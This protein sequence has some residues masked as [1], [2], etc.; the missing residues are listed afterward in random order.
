LYVRE[1][2]GTYDADF[3]WTNLALNMIAFVRPYWRRVV[4][5]LPWICG[6]LLAAWCYVIMIVAARV[7]VLGRFDDGIE[8]TTVTYLLHGQLAFTDF[9]EPY[10]I[11]LGIPG[12]LPHLLGIDS[13]FA[14]RLVYGVFPALVTLLVTPLVW[15]R[16]GAPMGVLVGLITITST[17]PRYSMGFAALFGFALIVDSAVRRTSTGTL[18]EAVERRPR[19]FLAAS[20]VCSLAGWARTEYAIFA[21]LWAVVLMLVLPRGRRRWVLS[22]A[23]ALFAA[24]PTLIVLV[25]GGL[26]HLW[27]FISYTLSS[28]ESGF[29]AQRGQPIE[30]HLLVDRL[31]ELLHLQFGTSTANTIVG[32][33]GLGLAV[34]LAGVLMLLV[35]GWR[36]RLLNRDSSYLTPFMIFACAVV[37][38]G[39]AARFSTSY[40]SIGNPV[41]W[42]AG[43]LLLGRLPSWALV[44]VFAFFAYP[45]A[46]GISPGAVY[47]TWQSRPPV[48]N[49]VV[50]PG[51][52]WIPIAE[53][54]GPAS[55][56]AL[57]AEWRALGL[58]GRPA[59]NVELRNDVAW[60]NDAIV[61]FLLN[62]P[63][64]AWPLTY[65]PG[66]VNTT[67]VER[68]T[69]AELC[70]NRAPVVQNNGDYPYTSGVKV[71]VGSRLLD[72]F[73]AVDYEVRAVAGFYRILMPSTPRCEL[74]EQ[75]NDQTLEALGLKWLEKGELA[76]AGALAIARLER[77]RSRHEQGSVS[78]AALAALGGYTLTSDELPA[79]DLGEAL[80]A[81]APGASP[82]KG[83]AA[84]AANP[85]PSDIERLA[86]QTAWI[87]HRS[88]GEA[89]TEQAAADVY[90][91]ALR[92]ANWPQAIANL[93]AIE[94]PSPGL[95]VTLAR[96][97][98]QGT[99]EFD[100]WRRGYFV[101]SGDIKD[102]IAAGLE[103]TGDYDRRR[104]PVEAGQAEL[105]LAT[106][107]GVT[108]GCA[109]TLRR[110][111]GMHSG[112]RVVVPP[113]GPGCTQ[114]EL[115]HFAG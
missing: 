85:W 93:S 37:L 74:P 48:N 54:G 108:P 29:H 49:R 44:V 103:L 100:R 4:P 2:P 7:D 21:A 115:A 53:D 18:Q 68:E 16:C 8:Y 46:P 64:A 72:E 56:A 6:T 23:T 106:Y 88:P 26:R 57:I 5:W 63:A 40:G 83:L 78:D 113:T 90:S 35:P 101:E 86:A 38:Y 58:D 102:S 20:I 98:A 3:C 89:G 34:V 62:A 45:F 104:D 73:L 55:M 47:D 36:Q 84:A 111:A 13:V 109:L 77:A 42:V 30:W 65:D 80:R 43:A 27:W 70:R 81:L 31:T 33:Y 94:P 97:G 39:Q 41:F 69:V 17:V 67:K 12:V 14:L 9:Y 51:F 79:G 28:S 32:S 52:N 91:L 92:R 112:V 105:E 61:G 19:L 99:P 15:R 11:G 1:A 114:P 24:L 71:Y 22:L 50:V 76:E 60:G 75:L 66:L 87:A 25:T 110:N 95:F 59:V 10:G 82:A 96:R 107:P